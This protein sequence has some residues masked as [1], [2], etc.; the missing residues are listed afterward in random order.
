MLKLDGESYLQQALFNH[1]NYLKKLQVTFFYV[2][3]NY[4]DEVINKNNCFI[5]CVLTKIQALISN[6]SNPS[7]K[8]SIKK[9][10]K[11]Y[12]EN[13]FSWD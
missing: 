10:T 11:I 2:C 7:F 6:F 8:Y 1:N 9:V 12:T 3:T 5:S 13:E 4:Y